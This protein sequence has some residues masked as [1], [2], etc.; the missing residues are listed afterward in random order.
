MTKFKNP[1]NV[2]VWKVLVIEYWN[3]EFIWNLPARRLFGGVV[4]ICDFRYKTPSQSQTSLTW[5][6][7][8]GFSG[9]N[10]DLEK[11]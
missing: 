2:S 3:L 5:P 7:G 4:G 1:N 6:K 9:Q 11:D 10:K 8:P